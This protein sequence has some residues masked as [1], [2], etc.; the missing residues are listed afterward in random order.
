MKSN[1]NKKILISGMIRSGSTL[2]SRIMNAHS[3]IRIGSD[4]LLFIYKLCLYG[5]LKSQ[6]LVNKNFDEFSLSSG[7][8]DK[9]YSD[10]V[11]LIGKTN[12][13][14]EIKSQ[15]KILIQNRLESTLYMEPGLVVNM[16]NILLCQTYGELIDCLYSVI[17]NNGDT[18]YVG[19]KEAY[20]DDFKPWMDARYPNSKF[21]HIIKF[22]TYNIHFDVRNKNINYSN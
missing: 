15:E 11:T 6:S 13:D 1:N 20:C 22:I 14:I 19:T 3:K 18:E 21:I 8:F 7:F 10:I 9:T 4:V 16:N 2:I 17:R 12:L 5:E